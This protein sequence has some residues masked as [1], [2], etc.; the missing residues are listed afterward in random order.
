MRIA[1]IG[2]KGIPARSGGVEKHVENIA[3]RQ[4]ALGHE[5]FVY[6][7]KHYMREYSDKTHR[8]VHLISTPSI[9]TK[10]LDAISHTFFSTVHALFSGYDVIH[11]QSIGPALLSFIPKAFLRKTRVIA[12]FHCQ[13]YFHKK[14][15]WFAKMVLHIGEYIACTVPHK[16]I[17]VSEELRKYVMQAYGREATVIANGASVVDE[18]ASDMLKGLGLRKDHY[19]LS[20]GRLVRHKGVHYLIEA[21]LRL[22]KEQPKLLHGKKLVIVGTHAETRDYET[23]LKSLAGKSKSIVFLGE[24]TGEEL[25]QVFGGAAC[26]V[27]PSESEGMSIALLEAM[28]YGL[29]IVASDI[30]ANTEVLGD[31]GM[32]FDN[33]NVDALHARLSEMLADKTR[34]KSL[35]K[36]A[37]CRAT[38]LYDWGD[39]AKETLQAYRLAYTTE[40]SYGKNLLLTMKK[41]Y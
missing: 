29:P 24:R 11:Y 8:G 26:F 18:V 2:Q 27:Q 39:I 10:H 25:H 20:V 16:T 34:A 36:A 15:S 21:F 31:T 4:A 41:L 7:R 22:K 9:R 28:S 5:V 3:V 35:G 14:W 19:I 1:F 40:F 37:K 12:T 23:F 30:E 32:L 38:A 13:D 6:V 33:K 17:V